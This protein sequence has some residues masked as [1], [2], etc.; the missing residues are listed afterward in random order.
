MNSSNL[1]PA[2]KDRPESALTRREC[3]GYGLAALGCPVL[4]SMPALAQ[5]QSTTPLLG[6]TRS[7]FAITGARISDA[8]LQSAT[9]LFGVILDTSKELRAI[10]LGE[11]EPAT[12][13]TMK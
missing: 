1:V 11:I 3:L 4:G 5:G 2:P 10:D 8:R 12:T 6:V 7:M 13:F 9:A